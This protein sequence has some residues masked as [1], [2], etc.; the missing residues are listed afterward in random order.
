MWVPEYMQHLAKESGMWEVAI[1]SKDAP[2]WNSS[3][4]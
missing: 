3:T 1:Q 4:P 2:P